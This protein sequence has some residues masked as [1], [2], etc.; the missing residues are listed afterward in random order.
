MKPEILY[1]LESVSSFINDDLEVYPMTEKGEPDI[2][3]FEHLSSFISD[4]VNILSKDD[5]N[6]IS[7]LIYWLDNRIYDL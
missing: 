3:N 4:W 7:E 6:M 5:D 1:P 2:T